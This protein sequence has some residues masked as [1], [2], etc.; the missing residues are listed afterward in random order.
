MIS[1]AQVEEV[2]VAEAP[3][4]AK[5]GKLQI[6]PRG[7][8]AKKAKG[9][10]EGDASLDIEPI[11]EKKQEVLEEDL[12]EVSSVNVLEYMSKEDRDLLG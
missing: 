12:I 6:R 5:K 8:L 1:K 7:V 9:P 10:E 4:P 3:K 11:I 2:K